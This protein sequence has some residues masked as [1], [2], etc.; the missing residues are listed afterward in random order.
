MIK[1]DML[2]MLIIHSQQGIGDDEED[3]EYD[4][5]PKIVLSIRSFV[6]CLMITN[7]NDDYNDGD[8]D[9]HSSIVCS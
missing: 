5:T 1:I 3:F 4:P 2:K 9:D 8:N 6:G 7:H